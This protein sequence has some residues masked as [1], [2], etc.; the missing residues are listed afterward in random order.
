MTSVDPSHIPTKHH[1]SSRGQAIVYSRN[2]KGTLVIPDLR[3]EQSY[4]RSLQKGIHFEDSQ[5]P[6]VNKNESSSSQCGLYGVPLSIGWK[7]VFYITFRDQ[8]GG[9]HQLSPRV[10]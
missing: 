3:F 9:L 4:L 5:S 1:D 7:H 2:K 6:V 8:V 10:L